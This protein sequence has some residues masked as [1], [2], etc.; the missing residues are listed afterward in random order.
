MSHYEGTPV[1]P[2]TIDMAQWAY[3]ETTKQG[4]PKGM[5]ACIVTA[6]QNTNR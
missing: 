1:Q 3:T 6:H 4:Q 2:A 5:N